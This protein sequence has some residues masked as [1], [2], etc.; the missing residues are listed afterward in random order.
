LEVPRDRNSLQPVA[1]GAGEERSARLF[2]VR[3]WL[4]RKLGDKL[5]LCNSWSIGKTLSAP[6]F[7]VLRRYYL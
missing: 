4:N 3:Q 2:S 1:V 5:S 7:R 6:S